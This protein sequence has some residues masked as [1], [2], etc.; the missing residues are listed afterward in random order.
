MNICLN[1]EFSGLKFTFH[2][3]LLSD[4]KKAYSNRGNM[5]SFEM[6]LMKARVIKINRTYE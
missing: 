5:E 4:L 6:K 1:E 3:W 2:Y